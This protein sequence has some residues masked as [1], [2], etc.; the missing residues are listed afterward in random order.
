MEKSENDSGEGPVARDF[1]SEERSLRLAKLDRLRERGIPPYP[2]GF[3][4]DHTVAEVAVQA[5]EPAPDTI[6]ATTVRI[7]GRLMLIRNHGGVI[8]ATLRDQSGT[9]QVAFERD[10]LDRSGFE[11]AESL[12][13]GDW[14]GIEGVVITTRAG[15]LTVSATSLELL[16]KALRALP[17]KHRGLTD[18][19]SRLRQ[20]YLDLI[21]NPEI[22]PVFDI[23]SKVIASI[24]RT[25]TDAD[26]IEVETP[27][28]ASQAGGAAA[29]PFITHH[30][31]LN[32]EMYLRVALELPLKRLV[33]GGFERVFELSR[34]FRNEGLDTR[35]NPE[36]TLL[37]AYQ[38]L[39]DYHDMM[40]LVEKIC[41]NAARDAIGTTVVEVEGQMIDLKPPWRRVTMADLVKQVTGET[42][43][44]SMPLEE[45]REICDRLEV[46][47]EPGWG[48]GRLL[49]EVCD[50]TCEETLIQPTMV[51]DYPQEISP[52]AKVH[53]DDPDLTE[54]FE[55]VI[56]GRELA[57]AYSELNDPVDQKARF[58]EE[59][60]AGA[61]GD[62]EAE[63][64][65]DDYIRALEYGLP[66]TGGLGIGV[67]RLVMLVAEAVSI[68]DVILFPAM[69][70]E[71]GAA[72]GPAFP[73][74]ALPT[75]AET[76][77]R[78]AVPAAVAAAGGP[79][80][81]AAATEAEPA[82][83]EDGPESP[84][85]PAAPEPLAP[86]TGAV[87]GAAAG[88]AAARKWLGWLTAL[89]GFVHL[90][91]LAPGIDTRLGGDRLLTDLIGQVSS[92]V[93]AAVI[94]LFLLVIAHQIGRGKRRAW[95][96]A[97]LL[98]AIGAVVNVLNGPHPVIALYSGFMAIA[99]IWNRDSFGARPDPAS[100][101]D[102]IR[103]VPV[104]LAGVFAFGLIT[105][106]AERS[107]VNQDLTFGGMLETTAAGLVGLDGPYTYNGE[108]FA[109][110]YPAALLALGIAGLALFAVLVFRAV[111]LKSAPSED[112]RQKASV[113]VHR[114]GSG[115]L[116][117]FALRSDKSYFFS[118]DGEA[119]LAYTYISG[120]ALVSGDPIGRPGSTG[121]VIDQF[122]AF[123]RER[124][125][126][127]AFLA[128]READMD[129]YSRRGFRSVYLGDEAIIPCDRF[130]L[131]GSA[132][133]SVRSAVKRVERQCDFR[134]MRESD[135][136]PELC[137]QLNEIRRRWR[138]DAPERGFTME[139]GRDVKGEN[140]DFLLA[141]AF[142]ADRKPLGFL[143]LVPCFGE[144]PGWSLD[145]MQRDPDAP[146]GMTEYLIANSALTLGQQG[147][148]RLSM[149]FAAWGR[150][151]DDDA[152][153]SLPQK[154]LRKIASVFNPFFQIESLRNFNAKFDPD[155]WPRSIVIEEVESAPKVS[156]LYA[157]SEG[158]LNVPLI[159]QKLIPPLRAES[160]TESTRTPD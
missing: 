152:R 61:A 50:E 71:D 6:T 64:V 77:L 36:F 68:R 142:G 69:R 23:R 90:L 59:A 44:P 73:G 17:D 137:A 101:L 82:A 85:P 84:S 116:D 22:R 11:D 80:T 10:R 127:I 60:K 72:T 138:G 155:W 99:L 29:R 58:E 110:F 5:G 131:S 55:V 2:P 74:G 120:F 159:G 96:V 126:K 122:I 40:D 114:Y 144:D 16:S 45:A 38:A 132:M 46:H 135:A 78:T 34:V 125:W 158:F 43:H 113:L 160:G 102:A 86:T 27:V 32:I 154:A 147:F 3:S 153:L 31:S 15:E 24:R 157:T 151:F 48:A 107:H 26:F 75:A 121:R 105:L 133:K 63:S 42:M 109:D 106:L 118:A 111:A 112:D 123:C 13:R 134:L 143:R 49:A 54:R 4:R 146:N 62:E 1:V 53:R 41:S 129:L 76:A 93:V 119:M 89:A 67:D 98:F 21:A 95:F 81:D 87:A 9:I 104:Y 92:T 51:C 83:V 66:P 124:N 33:V 70:P 57:N 35:H 108:F 91:A 115:T 100:L 140:P 148:R 141:V 12:D 18:V 52:L 136:S 150:L 39:G 156:L 103:F 79:A 20:R 65:D 128:V 88:S 19:D 8:F 145:L 7:A 139:L 25:L 14:V 30:N 37:E 94:G 28:L 117:Y 56:A 97:T 149:N 130:T 47:Y